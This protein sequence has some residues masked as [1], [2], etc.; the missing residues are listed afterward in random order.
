MDD[1]FGMGIRETR[2]INPYSEPDWA[3]V[4]VQPDV[5]VKAAD[6]LE[7]AERL[8]EDRLEE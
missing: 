7:T 4:G 3:V 6:T 2:P 8:A 1:H 5:K